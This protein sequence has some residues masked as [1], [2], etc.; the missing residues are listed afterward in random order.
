MNKKEISEELANKRTECD[1]GNKCCK[2][3]KRESL[4]YKRQK[5]KK[6]KKGHERTK[7][8]ILEIAQGNRD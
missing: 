1:K 8:S 7:K 2:R 6:K 3:R 5:K 4:K